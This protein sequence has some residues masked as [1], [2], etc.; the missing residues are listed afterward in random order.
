MEDDIGFCSSFSF[1]VRVTQNWKKHNQNQI[2]TKLCIINIYVIIE[3][4]RL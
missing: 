3:F 4:N 2:N 1:I